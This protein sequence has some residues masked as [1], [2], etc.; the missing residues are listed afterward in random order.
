MIAFIGSREGKVLIF[1]I[2][3]SGNVKLGETR[4]GL[5]YGGISAIDVSSAQDKLIAASDSGEIFTIDIL[6]NI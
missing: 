2:S 1:K 6:T 4:S 5:A 3:S